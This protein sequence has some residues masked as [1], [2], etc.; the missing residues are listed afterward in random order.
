MENDLKVEKILAPSD[1]LGD[2]ISALFRGG[3]SEDEID[4]VIESIKK[5]YQKEKNNIDIEREAEDLSQ[6]FYE[7]N[8]VLDDEKRMV[9]VSELK[10]RL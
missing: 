1:D 5:I 2:W 6:K 3:F 10:R 4:L 9:F 7:N 8:F